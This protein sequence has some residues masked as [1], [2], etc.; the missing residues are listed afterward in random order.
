MD[1]KVSVICVT[2]NQAKYIGQALESIVKQKTDFSFQVFVGDDA[3]TDGTDKIVAEYAKKY[4]ELIIP[5]LRKKN[6]GPGNNSID[7]Y[8][9]VNTPYVAVCDGDDYWCDEY[10][11]QKQVDFLDSHPDYMTVFS[12]SRVF[13]EDGR[14]DEILPPLETKN[15]LK[16][17]GYLTP[18]DIIENNNVTP[19][20]L[21]W[22]WQLS[23]G[24]PD[25]YSDQIM[26]DFA[27]NMIH[28][29]EGKVGYIP[30]TLACY[31]R[32]SNGIWQAAENYQEAY[33]KYGFVLLNSFVVLRDYYQGLYQ[34]E[35]MQTINHILKMCFVVSRQTENFVL[36]KQ[37]VNS[38]PKE[39]L[40]FIDKQD[41]I[42]L[43]KNRKIK[44]LIIISICSLFLIFIL[45]AKVFI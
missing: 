12:Q 26:G 8:K 15:L 7:L 21:M 27:L 18:K 4:P 6:V 34:K 43:K 22:R 24:F 44:F 38:F 41:A 10:K 39:V 28:A 1:K 25:W 37:I 14:P 42:C 23:Q 16:K 35:F 30:E 17:R 19:V 45:L 11:L 3:S 29:K 32:H 20:S 31:R 13:F 40:S 9:R 33:Q 5:V 2:Y 36:V